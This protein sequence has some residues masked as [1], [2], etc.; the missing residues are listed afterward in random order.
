VRAICDRW[1]QT[2][3][4]GRLNWY[5]KGQHMEFV[6]S[7][8]MASLHRRRSRLISKGSRQRVLRVRTGSSLALIAKIGILAASRESIDEAS[9]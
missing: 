9:R 7:P 1:A 5:Y 3:L 8:R 2:M 6:E 4:N